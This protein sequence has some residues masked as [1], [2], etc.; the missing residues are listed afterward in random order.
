MIDE[1]RRRLPRVDQRAHAHRRAPS[2]VVFGLGDH[3]EL[4]HAGQ[5]RIASVAG[6]GGIHRRRVD[7]RA[8]DDRRDQRGLTGVELMDLLAEIRPRRGADPADRDRAPLPEIDLV[9]VRLEDTFLGVSRLDQRGQPRFAQL[10]EE[11]PLG[12]E[13]SHLDELLRDRAPAFFDSAGAQVGPGRA[14]QRTTVEPPVLEEPLV[15]SREHGIDQD[16][17]RLLE[18]D[19]PVVFSGPVRRAPEHLGLQRNARDFLAIACDP[20]DPVVEHV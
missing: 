8:A 2:A 11:R 18:P 15:F 19:G 13:Q 20:G 10:P 5:H 3:P 14:H 6:P 9:Q 12:T 17:R 7:V 4:P 16:P 1:V